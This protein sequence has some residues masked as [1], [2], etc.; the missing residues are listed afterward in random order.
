MEDELET[1]RL[2]LEQLRVKYDEAIRRE[3]ELTQLV[4]QLR[5]EKDRFFKRHQDLSQKLA[6]LLRWEEAHV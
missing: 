3:V 5:R 4:A 2:G 6:E 1:M